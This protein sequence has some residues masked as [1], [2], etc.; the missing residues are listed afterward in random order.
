MPITEKTNLMAQKYF[1]SLENSKDKK[2]NNSFVCI[3]GNLKHVVTMKVASTMYVTNF[4][5][6]IFTETTIFKD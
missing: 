6:E 2:K 4:S 5:T 1:L 3:C